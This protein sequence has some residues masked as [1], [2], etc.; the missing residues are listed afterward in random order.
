MNNDKHYLSPFPKICLGLHHP[1]LR[2]NK[3]DTITNLPPS[4]EQRGMWHTKN[5]H[6]N[7]PGHI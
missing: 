5:L 6:E 7:K 2:V 3:V 4:F 1:D